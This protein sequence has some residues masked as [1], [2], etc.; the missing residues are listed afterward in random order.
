MRLLKTFA[1]RLQ[2]DFRGKMFRLKLQRKHKAATVLQSWCK[3]MA[4]RKRFLCKKF[5]QVKLSSLFR[6]AR[7]RMLVLE[8]LQHSR[9]TI[10]VAK[11]LAVRLRVARMR[12]AALVIQRH[13]RGVLARRRVANFQKII[14]VQCLF[15][16]YRAAHAVDLRRYEAHVRD[17]VRNAVSEQHRVQQEHSAATKIQSYVRGSLVRHFYGIGRQRAA[18][19]IQRAFVMG[20]PR[21]L[22]A[23]RADAAVLILLRT[24]DGGTTLRSALAGSNA[25]LAEGSPLFLDPKCIQPAHFQRIRRQVYGRHNHPEE[26]QVAQRRVAAHAPTRRCHPHPGFCPTVFDPTRLEAEAKGSCPHPGQHHVA[27]FGQEVGEPPEKKLDKDAGLRAAGLGE[28]ACS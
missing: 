6:Q 8:V 18:G 25:V 21:R 22:K 20:R 9:R 12:R 19:R 5:V 23:R 28:E 1:V 11:T 26:V 2:A 17:L 24:E 10:S 15:R 3:Q 7:A 16:R 14:R 27:M 13:C 4:Q